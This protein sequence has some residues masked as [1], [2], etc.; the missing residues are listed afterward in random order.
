MAK[1]RIRGSNLEY[2]ISFQEATHIKDI[3]NNDALLRNHRINIGALSFIKSDIK[4]IELGEERFE[5]SFRYSPYNPEHK[6]KILVS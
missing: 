2:N 5:G 1:L 6:E 3:F 4:S